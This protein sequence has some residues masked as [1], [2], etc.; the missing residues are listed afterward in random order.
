MT[1]CKPAQTAGSV[2]LEVLSPIGFTT[3]AQ[4]KC[5]ERLDKLEGKTI[6]LHWNGKPGA[7]YLL[8]EIKDQLSAK[9]TNIEFVEWPKGAA[10]MKDVKRNMKE[11]PSD[12][13]ILAVGD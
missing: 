12:A 6:A 11:Y 13:A 2:T 1:R 9:Y 8:A 5:A 3:K 10:W 4:I 7:Q